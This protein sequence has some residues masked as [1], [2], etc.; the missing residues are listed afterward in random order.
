MKFLLQ[1]L[2]LFLQNKIDKSTFMLKYLRW[3]WTGIII[4]TDNS[5]TGRRRRRPRSTRRWIGRRRR[6]RM[7]IMAV[8][9]R[10]GTRVTTV[11]GRIRWRSTRVS[12]MSRSSFVSSMV[13][14]IGPSTASYRNLLLSPKFV[15]KGSLL[16]TI[17]TPSALSEAII[18][19]VSQ[20]G[21]RF[22]PRFVLNWIQVMIVEHFSSQVCRCKGI[23]MDNWRGCWCWRGVFGVFAS[24]SRVIFVL[25]NGNW[26]QWAPNE[27]EEKFLN[28][29]AKAYLLISDAF[30][31]SNTISKSSSSSYSSSSAAAAGSFCL[32][33]AALKSLKM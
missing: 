5:T 1:S 2:L 27:I 19:V 18:E 23:K 25:R 32:A 15:T 7:I 26:S 29:T 14:V 3:R 21:T 6:W 4:T 10:R 9:V 17:S 20:V 31:E 28:N 13:M 30:A 22:T 33:G 24:V 12:I 16:Y 8:M 11:T